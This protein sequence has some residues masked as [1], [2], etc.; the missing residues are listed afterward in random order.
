LGSGEPLR[1]LANRTAVV[2]VGTTAYGKFPEKDATVL[3]AEAFNNAL[4]DSGLTRKDID[5]L[6][7]HNAPNYQRISEMLGIRTRYMGHQLRWGAQSGVEMIKAVGALHSGLTNCVALIMAADFAG[8]GFVFG[9]EGYRKHAVQDPWE[10]WGYGNPVS[11]LAAMFQ[12]HSQMFGTKVE[13]LAEIA[14]TFR[15]HANLN[16]AA[17]F[18]NRPMTVQDY[19]D[20]PLIVEP[21]R[22]PDCCLVNDGAVC[23]ILTTSDRAA[24]CRKA[25]IYIAGFGEDDD[26]DQHELIWT[27]DFGY[28]GTRATA[29]QAF[30]MAGLTRDD[31]DLLCVYDHFSPGVIFSLEGLGFCEQGEGGEFVMGGRLGINGALPTNPMGG[32]LSESYLFGWT[33]H[34]EAVRQL[35]G[36]CGARQVKDAEVAVWASPGP[37]IGTILYTR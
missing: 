23:I 9:G 21:L 12:R 5:G 32:H 13:S 3:A 33:Q 11:R 26:F 6:V 8:S 36:E 22:R 27:P 31:V 20:S 18:H 14:V 16:P 1:A 10:P 25:P 30:E 34:A 37:P 28:A 17:I 7:I 19:M 29:N 2:G 15:Q 35:R 4:A 24:D